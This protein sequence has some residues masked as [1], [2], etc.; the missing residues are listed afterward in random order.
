MMNEPTT[1][2]RASGALFIRECELPSAGNVLPTHA[3]KYDHTMFFMSGRALLTTTL[4][5]G[6]VCE[7]QLEAP[8]THL[9]E[10]GIRHKIL[11]LTDDVRFSCVFVHRDAVG[12]VALESIDWKAYW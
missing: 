7:Y 9:V 1:T 8:T 3:H 4:P 6:T 12:K 10:K 5:D 2:E 11:A